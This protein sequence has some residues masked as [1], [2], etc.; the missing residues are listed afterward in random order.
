MSSLHIEIQKII[1]A[2][3]IPTSSDFKKWVHAALDTIYTSGIIGIRIVDEVEIQNL[4]RTY[5]HKN[6]PT[7]VLSFTYEKDSVKKENGV[8]FLGDI[9]LCASVIQKEAKARNI[10][11][12]KHWA[13]MVIHG[14]LHI[15]GYLHNTQKSAKKMENKEQNILSQI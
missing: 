7:N 6:K 8:P 3:N 13:H 4:N 14:C 9:V 2:K 11:A 10:K 1:V 12:K 5:R 15:A